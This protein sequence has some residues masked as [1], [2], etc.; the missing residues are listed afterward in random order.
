[1]I[2]RQLESRN[3]PQFIPVA[4]SLPTFSTW[5][6][7]DF[8]FNNCNGL[9][10]RGD[11]RW[12]GRERAAGVYRLMWNHPYCGERSPIYYDFRW[13]PIHIF[14]TDGRFYGSRPNGILGLEQA[15]WLINGIQASDAPIRMAVFS[16]Q[17]VP[18]NPDGE[19][20][21]ANAKEERSRILDAIVG[22]VQS[23]VLFLSGDV[24]RSE[25]QRY[26][27]LSNTPQI[28]E[29]TSSPLRVDKLNEPLRES[30][31]RLWQTV[32]NSFALISV[33]YQGGTGADVT[34]LI[35]IEAIDA[36]GGILN[37][38]ASNTPCRSVWNLKTRQLT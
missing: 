30:S 23:P 32:Q 18:E 22:N 35:T 7:H 25:L 16:S 6:D 11:A 12:V 17:F 5:D 10:D 2:R 24:H 28:L 3:H 34:G 9:I 29:I 4:R 14:M 27:I 13:G 8:G 36:S 15:T 33:D 19:S 21:F 26:P 38:Y 1:M 37:S 20:F 31:N